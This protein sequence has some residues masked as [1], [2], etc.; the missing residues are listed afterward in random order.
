MDAPRRGTADH[1]G[2]R[3]C[4]LLLYAGVDYKLRSIISCV[5]HP[6]KTPPLQRFCRNFQHRLARTEKA[7]ARPPAGTMSASE[8]PE[9]TSGLSFKPEFHSWILIPDT[10]A[11]RKESSEDTNGPFP[12]G[13]PEATTASEE[14]PDTSSVTAESVI[15]GTT[16][17][18]MCSSS[19]TSP[20]ASSCDLSSSSGSELLIPS[21]PLA[22]P[23]PCAAAFEGLGREERIARVICYGGDAADSAT[24]G[25]SRE[26]D[27]SVPPPLLPQLLPQLSSLGSM[28]WLGR[29]FAIFAA[30]IASH[31]GVLVIGMYLGGR[32]QNA[33]QNAE[34]TCL[35]RRFSSGTS[36][37]QGRICA[38]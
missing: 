5:G 23:R 8:T 30:L 37:W 33:L 38:A 12:E 10:A 27:C 14:A 17:D 26:S 20:V 24:D 1:D 19:A 13:C 11:F 4:T 34:L 25:S 28:E 7:L 16:I 18:G 29:P 22:L 35:L 3:V 9:A 21:W 6:N 2:V 36:G 32:H 15:L 31:F